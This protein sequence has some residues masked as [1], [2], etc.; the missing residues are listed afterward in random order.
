[1]I[2]SIECPIKKVAGAA[3][4]HPALMDNRQIL[5]YKQLDEA[6]DLAVKNLQ[7][8]G[9]VPG[10]VVAVLANNSIPYAI[11][12][13]AA[14]RL[15]FILMPLNTRLAE[16]DWRDQLEKSRCRLLVSDRSVADLAENEISFED[17][18]LKADPNEA[19]APYPEYVLEREALIIFSSGSSGSSRGVVLTWR[20]LYYSALGA[21]SVLQYDEGDRWI[22][23]LPFFHIGGIS[24]LF[25]TVLAG[26]GAY[27]MERFDAKEIIDII[28][29]PDKH[30]LSVVPTMLDA[31]VDEDNKSRL[32]N[33]R[34]IILGGAPWDNSLHQKIIKRALPVLTTYGMTEMSSMITLLPVDQTHNRL[35]TAGKILPHRELMIANK[36]GEP[37]P[38]EQSGRIKVRGEVLFSHYLNQSS[39]IVNASDWFDTGDTGRL[40]N[41]GYLTVTGR[42][43]NIIISGGENIDLNQIEKAIGSI[44]G[45]T[46]VVVLGQKDDKWGERPVAFIGARDAHISEKY[47]KDKLREI[48][49]PIFIPDQVIILSSLPLT[50]SGKYDRRALRELYRDILEGRD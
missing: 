41:G 33:S 39:P 34:A 47:I 20:N 42:A 7:N 44:D 22:A 29:K 18:L 1:M 43:D 9:V 30:Y 46:G 15:G 37:L 2:K 49:S 26:C 35:H 31:L 50:G 14:F 32:Q 24:I 4:D 6:V 40:D 16:S 38:P 23:A 17:L 36:D 45:V 19:A 8:I 25:R 27:I 5:T 10:D 3:P 12:F 11:L 48:L 28:D 13:Y 21:A